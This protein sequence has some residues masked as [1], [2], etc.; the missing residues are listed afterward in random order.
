MLSAA[1]AGRVRSAPAS[2][3]ASMAFSLSSPAF[4]DHDSI[5]KKY[6]REGENVTPPLAWSDA[7]INTASFALEVVDPDAPD[8]AAP[9]RTF[10]HWVLYN[11]PGSA[12]SLPDDIETA[13][14]PEGAREG[15]NDWGHAGYDGPEPPKGRH[16]YFFKLY[17]LDAKIRDTQL[18][19]R[20]QLQSRMRGHI[21]AETELV[22]TYELEKQKRAA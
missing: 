4:G 5:A 3:E 22:G 13:G 6:T 7:P 11:L 9:Q 12:R 19:T 2:K 10:T 8:P 16:R 21:L 15:R 20:D 17:A 14:L 18:L 1:R